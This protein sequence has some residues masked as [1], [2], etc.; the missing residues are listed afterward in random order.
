MLKEILSQVK[1][2][3]AETLG[4]LKAYEEMRE[5]FRESMLEILDENTQKVSN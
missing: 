1:E 2:E 5:K 3:Q 4:Y